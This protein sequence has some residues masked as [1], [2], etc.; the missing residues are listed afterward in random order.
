MMNRIAPA[1]VCAYDVLRQVDTADAY[2][3]IALRTALAQ[4]NLS[5][6]DAGLTSE[7]VAGVLTA[8]RLLDDSISRHSRIAF[9]KLDSRVVAILR[10]SIYQI[11]FLSRIPDYAAV[12]D[13]VELAKQVAPQ[14]AGFVN[15]VLRSLLRAKDWLTMWHDLPQPL[16]GRSGIG[17]RLSYPDNLVDHFCDSFGDS[18][19]SEIMLAQNR[20][21]GR[22]LRINSAR[23]T[24]AEVIAL[25]AEEGVEAEES[26]VSPYGVRLPAGVNPSAL[27]A[28]TA[29]LCSIQGESSMLVAPL[30][31]SLDGKRVLDACAAPGG[32]ALHMAEL[33]ADNA[34][35]TAVDIHAHRVATIRQQAERL[36]L[37]S[38]QAV[39]AD[40]REVEGDYDAVLLDAPCSGLGTIGRHPDIKWRTKPGA[41]EAL[42]AL[43]R[44]LLD[45]LARRVRPGGVLLYTTCTLSPLENTVQI[46]RFLERRSDFSPAP[47]VLPVTRDTPNRPPDPAGQRHIWPQDF[48]S[49][50]FFIAKLQ[51]RD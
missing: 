39:V 4:S 27:R 25:L 40:A 46:E 8:R 12:A 38:V 43:Q 30:L 28:Y 42:A 18:F 16:P 17:L 2:A 31:G 1:R 44:E 37:H 26:P 49:D 23:C 13:A 10:M 11:V 9:A 14:A 7:L 50:G 34:S 36:R 35:I 24:R 15:A 45:T 5:A 32:K 48:G 6:V 29:G 33:A 3:H 21:N 20:R 19:G 41:I 51:R 47:F 22:T